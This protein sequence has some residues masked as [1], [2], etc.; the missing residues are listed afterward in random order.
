MK[1]I[2]TLS[3]LFTL[4][5]LTLAHGDAGHTIM[6]NLQHNLSSVEHLWPVAA[7][8]ILVAAVKYL[9]ARLMC[10]TKIKS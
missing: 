2:V 1:Q 8:I 4:P 5:G 6:A 3:L 9:P 7:A 10:K